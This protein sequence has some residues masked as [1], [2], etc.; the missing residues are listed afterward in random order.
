MKRI[1]LA[2]MAVFLLAGCDKK[3][4][5][6]P[7]EEEETVEEETLKLWIVEPGMDIEKARTML[8]FPK[9]EVLYES[10]RFGTLH[11]L[12]DFE[13]IGYPQDWLG[14]GYETDAIIVE[15]SGRNGI[16]NYSGEE[17]SPA[18]VNVHST[19]YAQGIQPARLQNE[20]GSFSFVYGYANTAA[21]K[22]FYYSGDY[23]E[24]TETTLDQFAYD[25]YFDDRRQAFFCIQEGQFGI[26][27]PI[28]TEESPVYGWLFEPYEG[29]ELP[30]NQVVPVVD[31]MCH[32]QS[33]VLC[34]VYGNVIMDTVTARGSYVEGTYINGHYRIATSEDTAFVFANTGTQISWSYHGAGSFSDGYAPVK[35]YG[36]WGYI[37]EMG[38]EVTDFIFTDATELN[39]G[40]AYVKY[41]G[42]Y[43]ILNLK[44][45]LEAGEEINIYTLYATNTNEKQLGSVKVNVSELN[46]RKGAGTA[47]DSEGNSLEGTTYPVFEIAEG[48]GYTWYRI[49]QEHWLPSDGEWMTYT[50]SAPAYGG[51]S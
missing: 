3:V 34:D 22:G 26:A 14:G 44:E 19:P 24:I 40:R 48:E 10:P 51:G 33:Y 28:Y 49:D 9:T 7:V 43:G 46:I 37:D 4:K 32:P 23:Q 15:K 6:L 11:V 39:H 35:K 29:G 30:A 2:V 41:N 12:G 1:M 47:Y 18:D 13:R 8:P 36:R 31:L 5:P 38:N 25:P 21:N 20:D 16:Y 17:V 42:V 45:A 27:A 50:E